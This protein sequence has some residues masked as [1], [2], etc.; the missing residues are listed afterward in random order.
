MGY[1]SQVCDHKPKCWT[2]WNFDLVTALD[3]KFR[4]VSSNVVQVCKATNVNV[5]VAQREKSDDP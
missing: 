1:H 3:E 5:M 4:A 2:N